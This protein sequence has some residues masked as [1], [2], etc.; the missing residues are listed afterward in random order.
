M[1]V[2]KYGTYLIYYN[3]FVSVASQT[4]QEYIKLTGQVLA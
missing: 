4:E 3:I 1:S 2:S